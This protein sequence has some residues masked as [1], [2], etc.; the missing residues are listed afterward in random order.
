M[1][2]TASYI[3]LTVHSSVQTGFFGIDA[4]SHSGKIWDDGNKKFSVTN[5]DDIGLAVSNILSK[6]DET[7]NKTV[8]ISSFETSLNDLLAAYKEATGVSEWNITHGEVEQGIKDAQETSKS[9]T[10]FMD[11]MRAM[12]LLGL[13]VGMTKDSGA[14]FVAEGLSDN[15]LLEMPRGSVTESVKKNLKL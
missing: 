7:A 9:A 15:D 5:M 13:L 8:Y 10:G 3:W 1:H 12:G 6:P 4:N 14:D 11:K 2:T